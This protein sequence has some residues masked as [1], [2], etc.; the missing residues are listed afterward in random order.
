MPRRI[1]RLAALVVAASAVSLFAS[2]S[3]SGAG[4]L[5]ACVKKN[6]SAHLFAKKP[7]CHK[8]EKRLSWNT[9]GP[10]GQK[11]A[12]G[13]NGVNGV[14][15]SSGADLTSHTPLPS[16]QS[17]SGWFA[18][19]SGSSTSG[20]VG[21][22]ISFS[23]PLA[24]GLTENHAVFNGEEATSTHCPGVGRADPGFLCLYAGEI[25]NLTFQHTL[26]FPTPK[27]GFE[28]DATGPFG[29]ALYF[30]VTK[31]FGFADGSWTVTA[32]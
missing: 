28:N 1:L 22:G 26:N 5:Y 14:N 32:P 13:A 31:S 9:V 11:G 12:P 30:A 10:A 16:G 23:Q 24:A 15:G 6:G 29:F 20:E 8:G 7:K 19:G 25:S 4:T 21:T 17:E 2:S 18:V 3:A 27:G